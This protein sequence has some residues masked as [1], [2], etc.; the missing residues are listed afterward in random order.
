MAT[1]S[2]KY[3]GGSTVRRS[4][5]SGSSRKST[6]KSTGQKSSP[7]S[8]STSAASRTG[9]RK[10]TAGSRTGTGKKTAASSAGT[11]RSTSARG[12][13]N[14]YREEPNEKLRNELLL[15][16]LFA[17]MAFLFLSNFGIMGSVGNILSGALFGLFGF[18]AYF[19]PV[20]AFGLTLFGYF[21]REKES[22]PSKIGAMLGLILVFGVLCELIGVDLSSQPNYQLIEIYQRS[23]QGRSGGGVLAG[24]IAFLL[25]KL[26]R[27]IGTVLM[28]IVMTLV[29]VIV[30]TERSLL[31]MIKDGFVDRDPYERWQ[32]EE[33]AYEEEMQEPEQEAQEES[34][35]FEEGYQAYKRSRQERKMRKEEE[36]RQRIME[37][38]RER[39]LTQKQRAMEK[40]A[41]ENNRILRMDHKA[42]GITPN[43]LLTEEM[44]QSWEQPGMQS[45]TQSEM[46]AGMQRGIQPEAAQE[47]AQEDIKQ[48]GAETQEAGFGSYRATDPFTAQPAARTES[49]EM[50]PSGKR[51]RSGAFE[52]DVPIM[53]MKESTKDVSAV[54]GGLRDELHEI[55]VNDLAF[56]AMQT[57]V[58]PLPVTA[59]PFAGIG[60]VRPGEAAPDYTSN[61]FAQ[62]II[63][64]GY[65]ESAESEKAEDGLQ[66]HGLTYESVLAQIQ[67]HGLDEETEQQE[68]S[69]DGSKEE[70]SISVEEWNRAD[71]EAM[72]FVGSDHVSAF[73]AP[74]SQQNAPA[75]GYETDSFRRDVM[76]QPVNSQP[77]YPS[78]PVVSSQGV[79][80][81]YSGVPSQQAAPDRQTAP[82]QSALQPGD[83][84]T[85][86]QTQSAVDQA[87]NQIQP[88][89]D[90]AVTQTQPTINQVVTQTQPAMTATAK[91]I[92]PEELEQIAVHRDDPREHKTA[93][94]ANR[95]LGDVLQRKYQLPPTSLLK[96]VE[97]K[98]NP[99]S[100]KELKETAIRL[101]ETLR[102]FGVNVT[103]TDISQGPT[104]TRYELQPEVG[105][106]VSRIVSLQD[107]IKLNLA[108]TDIR[109]EAPIPGK[110]AIGIEVPNRENTTV[111]FRELVES[112]EFQKSQSR[113]SFAV[114][115][116]IGGKTVVTDIA[117][118]P[119]LLIAGSTGSGKSVCIN[120]LIM[121]ILYKAKPEEVKLIM[122]DPKVVELSVYNGIPHLL[123]PVVTDPRKA[124]AALNWAVA[125]MDRRYGLI[126]KAGSRD[127]KGYNEAARKDPSG[128]MEILPQIV[129]VV[130]ELADLMMVAANDVEKAI[131]RLA[132]L[133]RA[134]GLHL[135]IA[136]QRPSVDVI[137]GLIKANMPSRIAFAVSSGVD[138]RTI[139]DMNG[140]EKLLGKGDMLFAPQ[141]YPKPARIQGAFISD[142]EVGN[143]VEFLA[144]ENKDAGQPNEIEKA[145]ES[146]ASGNTGVENGAAPGSRDD[147]RDEHFAEAGRFIIEKDKA[148][149]G[150]LQ[151]YYKIGFN[152]A[153][154]I[155]DQL[156]EA[157]VVSAEEGTKPR[158]VLMSIEE[159]EAF[160][161]SEE[162]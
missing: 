145:I 66:D 158:K 52:P 47:M 147:S 70:H 143:V 64:Q 148:S 102:T 104:V 116:D 86:N 162:A 55:T 84:R 112:E 35:P 43:T 57:P 12:R 21:F 157:G 151:R 125:E 31:E 36:A 101:Q 32:D 94:A 59:T 46:Q 54:E 129:I 135:I 120:T 122:V 107:D 156:C 73:S 37:K 13:S 76:T 67:S 89:V 27:T 50:S 58:T 126:A 152:R 28:L 39:S 154:R 4:S 153:A 51:E 99:E 33:D 65:V 137:T 25:Y 106:K 23:S 95:S 83:N 20:A 45:G 26:L 149:I 141:S 103:I 128:E 111:S 134:A 80:S 29:C 10:S 17:A 22:T 18:S 61:A 1:G 140:A 56:Q 88:A 105:V 155:M 81:V 14:Y 133:A 79:Q 48:S 160:L 91:Q 40:E 109:I 117:K 144:K 138:S 139:L 123:I 42:T 8:R 108:A 97:V 90:Q 150:M 11:R 68:V 15:L 24:S 3:N 159:F 69:Q 115:K 7:R 62:R 93:P 113:L 34:I 87:I 121:S 72:G 2:K 75:Y 60:V 16:L 78:E 71:S 110:A 30:I 9:S 74:Q 41:K 114:G 63:H 38:E 132:Q 5:A 161:E 85:I 82:F 118:M 49:P 130:D 92:R 136:T 53:Q 127:V 6:G 44:D 100:E 98:K 119:H 146:I 96:K 77:A 124:A 131:C 142:Q 19:M